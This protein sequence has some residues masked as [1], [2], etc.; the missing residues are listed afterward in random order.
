MD[1]HLSLMANFL[2]AQQLENVPHYP[3][4]HKRDRAN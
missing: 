2:I 1:N 4:S 3:V